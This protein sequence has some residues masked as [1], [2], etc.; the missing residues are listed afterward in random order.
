MSE[1]NE[2]DVTDAADAPEVKTE[3]SIEINI[4]NANL[5]YRSDFPEGE[6]VFWLESVKN[7]IIKNTFENNNIAEQA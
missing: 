2:V 3:F 7:L 5:S 6:T 1:N 4:S